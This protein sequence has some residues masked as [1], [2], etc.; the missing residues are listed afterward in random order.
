MFRISLLLLASLGIASAQTKVAIIN[1][2]N[3]VLETAEIKKAQSDLE[4]KFRPRQAQIER[5]Q[6]E[7]AGLQNQLQTGADKLTPQA[8]QDLQLTGTR[9]QRELTRASEDL[10]A[11]VD[12]ERNEVLQR[13]GQHMQEVVRKLA[14]ERGFD[15]VVDTTNAVFYKPTIDITKD[16]VAA[17]DKAYPVG[18]PAAP[19]AAPAK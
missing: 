2:N 12:R 1:I 5:L 9:K 6:K 11:D 8:Q 18:A 4:A 10:Q 16:A 19:A 13:T 3:A 15:L 7:I 17:Y 14:E